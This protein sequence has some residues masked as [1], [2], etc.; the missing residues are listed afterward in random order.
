MTDL[1][2]IGNPSEDPGTIV[3]Y[4]D[5][6]QQ[7]LD[8]DV[9]RSVSKVVGFYEGNI[10]SLDSQLRDL[11]RAMA[12]RL[13]STGSIPV[14]WLHRQARYNDLIVQSGDLGSQYAAMIDDTLSDSVRST[15][16]KAQD[17]AIALMDA[18]LPGYQERIAP[19]NTFSEKAVNRFLGASQTRGYND[20]GYSPL[21]DLLQS[22]GPDSEQ[23]V[24]ESI[25]QGLA[26]GL[27]PSDVTKKIK[28]DL[29]GNMIPRGATV[30]RTEMYRAYREANRQTF[31]QNPEVVPSWVWH[32]HLG[33]YTCA[34]CWAMHGQEFPVD[35]P[36]GSH[37]NCR[38]TMLPKTQTW[39]ELGFPGVGDEPDFGPKGS[40]VFDDLSPAK[41]RKI[42]GPKKYAM[43]K[44]GD[45]ALDDVVSVSATSRW[46]TTRTIASAKQ[47]RQNALDRVQREARLRQLSQKSELSQEVNRLR[48][49]SIRLRGYVDLDTTMDIGKLIRKDLEDYLPEGYERSAKELMDLRRTMVKKKKKQLTTEI[50]RSWPVSEKGQKLQVEYD[51]LVKREKSLVSKLRTPRGQ[52][53]DNVADLEDEYRRLNDSIYDVDPGDFPTNEDYRRRI[54]AIDDEITAVRARIR[55][56]KE[57]TPDFDLSD[58]VLRR[59]REIRDIGPG[60]TP[61]KIADDVPVIRTQTGKRHSSRNSAEVEAIFDDV[62]QLYPTEWMEASAGKGRLVF[63]T[64]DR[65]YQWERRGAGDPQFWDVTEIV[66]SGANAK[67]NFETMVHE[68]GHRIEQS[69]PTITALESQF[70]A[71]RVGTERITSLRTLTGNTS[72]HASEKARRDDFIHPYMGK[73]YGGNYW[74]LVSMGFENVLSPKAVM[75]TVNLVEDPDYLDF[76]LGLLGG[77]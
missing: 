29:R 15:V 27:H 58:P 38:C 14:T 40:D 64:A 28:N 74:E 26:Q 32:A 52:T 25:G 57:G 41:K 34:T 36:M 61:H 70:Y 69:H 2:R 67:E 77:A 62:T 51:A 48:D 63:G 31:L 12:N 4:A 5:R 65:G 68:V 22:Y 13:E 39:E 43:Y 66:S 47:A 56:A 7:D 73:D 45:I 33:D 20:V 10:S 17:D 1:T 54:N 23:I 72:Y 8:N 53:V 37:P 59:L 49:E 3:K 50:K 21:G 42:L 35:T 30:V 46:G 75:G 44:S 6:F 11:E 19:F 55:A 76:I 71:R 16:W 24:R 60:S 9:Q 18:S